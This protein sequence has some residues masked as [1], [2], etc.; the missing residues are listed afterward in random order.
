MDEGV[1]IEPNWDLAKQPA[2]DFDIDRRI[3]WSLSKA[4]ILNRCGMALCPVHAPH[5]E[6]CF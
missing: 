1:H 4:A 2:P 3:S 6:S 5:R